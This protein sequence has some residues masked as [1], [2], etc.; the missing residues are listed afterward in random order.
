MYDWGDKM[1]INLKQERLKKGLTQSNLGKLVNRNKQ[2]VSNWEHGISLPPYLVLKRL[3]EIF[4]K[5]IEYLV[6]EEE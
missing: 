2:S 4:D 3:S 1:P 5:P 6:E